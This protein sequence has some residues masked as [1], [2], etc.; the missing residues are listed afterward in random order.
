[1]ASVFKKG[2]PRSKGHWIIKWADETGRRRERSSGTTDKAAANRIA[3][4]IEEDVALRLSGLVDPRDEARAREDRRPITEHVEEY[5]QDLKARARS[6]KHVKDRETSVN[7]VLATAGVGRLSEMTC[8]RVQ[9]ALVQLR[10]EAKTDEAPGLSPTTLNRLASAV[11]GFA[12]WATQ[13]G[14]L[15]GNQLAGLSRYNPDTDR[16]R[17]RRELTTAEFA[18][19]LQAAETSSTRLGLSGPDRAMMYALAAGTGLRAGEIA[20][21]TPESFDLNADP[22]TVTVKAAYS[23]HRE[24]DVQPMRRD[25]AERLR[26]WLRGCVLRAPVFDT[27]RLSEKTAKLIK[28][29]LTAAGVPYVDED[30]RVAD[31]HA[32]RVS[33]V[34]A[35]VRAGAS[36]KEAQTLARHA[37]PSLTFKVYAKTQ[38]HDL[39]R[40]LEAMPATE[41]TDNVSAVAALATGTDGNSPHQIP[42]H[43]ARD[44]SPSVAKPCDERKGTTPKRAAVSPDRL[45]SCATRYTVLRRKRVARPPGL[46]PG[47]CGLEIRCSIRLS[48]GRSP[49]GS[50]AAQGRRSHSGK[51]CSNSAMRRRACS[52]SPRALRRRISRIMPAAVPSARARASAAP[53]R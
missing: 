48:Y 2:G 50:L 31:F 10:D 30:G 29:D 17:V 44:A 12:R 32:L 35:V 11:V 38:M 47:T 34:S 37:D 1:M 7:R 22:P 21:L 18:R 51:R 4:R 33:F 9:A 28:G 5:V 53:S 20:S 13:N 40:A 24:D 14:R 42:H 52:R 6:E 16:R 36:P 41:S 39:T 3:A 26:P 49:R 27:P 43:L 46:E 45:R 15:E 23:K 25:L 19:L 8:E